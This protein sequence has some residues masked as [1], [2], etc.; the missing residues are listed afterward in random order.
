MTD[1]GV[2][3]VGAGPV[4]LAL[5]IE[6][7]TR[8][9]PV[10]VVDAGDGTVG[11]PAGE[12]VFSRTME[13]LRQWG[14]SE[15]ARVESEPPVD[16]PHRI[17]FM[18]KVTGH[19]LTTFEIGASNA[20]P[21][22]FG[23]FTPEGPAFLSKFSFLP[24]LER[25]AAALPA[26]RIHHGLE[27]EDLAQ[28][29]RGVT[30]HVRDRDTESRRPVRGAYLVGC[31]GGRSTVR[32]RLGIALSGE[33]AQGRNLAVH[34]R[35]PGLLRLLETCA[36][37]RA[38]QVQTLA[39]T[40]RPYITVVNGV[41]EWR[42]SVYVT[43]QP[44]PN[45]AERWVREAVG[46]DV[47]VQVLSAQLWSGHRVV[48]DRYRVDRVFLAGDA[49]HL[50]WP[51]GGFGA[52][53]GIGDAVDLGW[54]LAAVLAGWGGDTLLD[55]YQAERRPIALRNVTE[56]SSNWTSD[57]RI[58]PDPVLDRDDADGD[59]ARRRTGELIREL[60][61]R[62]FLSIGVQLGYRYRHS[63]VIVPDGSPEP[64]DQPDVYVPSTWPG[65]RAPHVVLADGSSI[66]DAFGDGFTLVRA[67]EPTHA[68]AP[69][70]PED[71]ACDEDPLSTA[72]AARGLPLRAVAVAAA[73]PGALYPSR[74]TLVRPDGHVCWRGD[75]LPDDPDLL[76]D[77]VTGA[78]PVRAAQERP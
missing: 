39:S 57:A 55:S 19:L 38:A 37:G 15:Q 66:L 48:A 70:C 63:S 29:D 62:E 46:A 32:R 28:D 4:G 47:D 34:F 3:V 52:N 58:V 41:D 8:G 21:G 64:P 35:A 6:L 54:K 27:L 40:S 24:L 16:F 30:A 67:A 60:R 53:T 17:V 56:A 11:F 74:F 72:A 18:T 14:I 13:H 49:A 25:T 2:L 59:E 61:G 20:D 68:S 76:L 50:L 65:C 43:A 26:V 7:G 22:A 45:D 5:A 9:V 31:D 12:A 75:D 42:L 23:P 78:Q 33:F 69:T 10:D 51:K 36:G 1:D 71:A 44:S 77:T 73:G